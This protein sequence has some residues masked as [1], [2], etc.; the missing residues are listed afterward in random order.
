MN[1]S[2]DLSLISLIGNAS[3]LVQLVLALL[4]ARV[5]AWCSRVLGSSLQIARAGWNLPCPLVLPGDPVIVTPER[6]WQGRQNCCC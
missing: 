2:Q 6:W 1:V 3:V 5:A 4:L